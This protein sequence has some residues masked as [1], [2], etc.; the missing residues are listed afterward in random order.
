MAGLTMHFVECEASARPVQ[1]TL[2]S[3]QGIEY[4]VL[5][6]HSPPPLTPQRDSRRNHLSI[7]QALRGCKSLAQYDMTSMGKRTSSL[8]V[9]LP[10]W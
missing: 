6:F 5:G 1:Y 7:S 4:Y 10:V 8:V 2:N 3:V 9:Y